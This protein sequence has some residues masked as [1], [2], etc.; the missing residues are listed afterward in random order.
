MEKIGV[1]G[2]GTM[3]CGIAQVFLEHGYKVVLN[4]LN[5]IFLNKGLAT[6]NKNLDRSLE[7]GKITPENKRE[8]L[9]RLVLN[10]D[11]Q[12]LKECSLVI[13][14]VNEDMQIKSALFKKLDDICKNNTILASNTS[15]LSITEL[16]YTSKWPERVIG[17]H[18][19]NPV[20]VIRLVEIIKGLK[21]STE[22]FETVREL[23]LKIEKTPIRVEESPGF[24][25]NR[26]LI[27]MVNEAIFLYAEGVATADEID[28]AMKLGANH[29]IG[30][31]ALADLIGLDVVLAIIENLHMEIGDDKYRPHPLLKKMVR[32]RMLGRKTKIGFYEY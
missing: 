3:G 22:T 9:S 27:P 16:S 23:I 13:E 11:M 32:G 26:L 20:P 21:T 8:S 5:D 29:P 28:N 17:M 18:F 12:A 6:I 24:I 19:F 14:A 15:S 31:L 7:K 10:E 2:A 25:V 4:D 1:I 30:P